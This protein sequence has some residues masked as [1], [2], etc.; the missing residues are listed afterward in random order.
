MPKD[1]LFEIWIRKGEEGGIFAVKDEAVV[2]HY[3]EMAAI[4]KGLVDRGEV[5]EAVVL[6]KRVVKRFKKYTGEG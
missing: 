4:A 3:G 6:E 1:I 5:D 2:A